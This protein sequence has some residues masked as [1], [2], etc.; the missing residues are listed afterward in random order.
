MSRVILS[1]IVIAVGVLVVGCGPSPNGL[2]PKPTG[3]KV[4]EKGGE[5]IRVS[6]NGEFPPSLIQLLAH[7][8]RYHGKKVQVQGFLHVRFEGTAIYLSREDAEHGITRN[9]FWVSFDPKAVPFEGGIEPNSSTQSTCSLR[10]RSTRTT[11]ATLASGRGRSSGSPGPTNFDETRDI[12]P[13][14]AE[15]RPGRGR[16]PRCTGPRRREVTAVITSPRRRG[17]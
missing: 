11:S 15:L 8:D 14:S 3:P 6:P 9:G 12:S 5:D 16:T 13:H 17:R 2:E 4:G 10:G 1:G 7:P